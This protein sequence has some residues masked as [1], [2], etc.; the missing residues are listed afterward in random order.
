MILADA[1]S[2]SK[3]YDPFLTIDVAT[4]TGAAHAAIGH[5][6]T[7]VMGTADK[8]TFDN[9]SKSGNQTYERTVEFPFWDEYDEML[10]SDIADIK[11]IGGKVGGAITAGKFLEHFTDYPWIHMD[12]AGP[13]FMSSETGY[14]KKGG[15]GVGVRLLFDFLKSNY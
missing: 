8:T 15:T 5:Y 12:I 13:A 9:L 1:L 2:Y 10:K 6:G 3:H 7:V 11:N 4:L 14:L